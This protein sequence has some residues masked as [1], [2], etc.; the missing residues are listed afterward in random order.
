MTIT[1]QKA[2]ELLDTTGKNINHFTTTTNEGREI[3]GWICKSRGHKMG[4]LIIETVDDVETLQYVQGMPK[5]KYYDQREIIPGTIPHI[6]EKYDGTNIVA[7]P[8]IVDGIVEEVI[9]KSRGLPQAEGPY[10]S[11]TLKINGA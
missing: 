9:F 8:L 6:F 2:S 4:S 7:F 1:K 10:L 5:I 3:K 11:K